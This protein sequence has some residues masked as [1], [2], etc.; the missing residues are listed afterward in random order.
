MANWRAPAMHPGVVTKHANEPWKDIHWPQEIDKALTQLYEH[1]LKD[2]VYGWY[3][4]ISYDE[5]F[6]QEIRHLL[7]HA[8]AVLVKRLAKIDLATLITRK[9]IPLG[10][11]HV[12]AYHH[13]KEYSLAFSAPL[14]ECYYDFVGTKIHPAS[15]NLSLIHI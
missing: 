4:Q 12:D 2:Y 5:E 6:V 3:G 10:L 13:A 7:R 15:H 9:A 8:T 11:A 1:L 14:A